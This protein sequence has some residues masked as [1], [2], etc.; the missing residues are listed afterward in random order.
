[1]SL[2][3][4][5]LV[6]QVE[7]VL[8]SSVEP[9][10][11]CASG[12]AEASVFSRFST[13][14]V[15]LSCRRRFKG[16]NQ[17]GELIMPT[18]IGVGP[19]T[20]RR[21][22]VCQLQG[23]TVVDF[24]NWDIFELG[25][26]PEVVN[27]VHRELEIEGIGGASPRMLGGYSPALHSAELVWAKFMRAESAMLVSS[28]NQALFSLMTQRLSRGGEVLMF[29]GGASPMADLA[30]LCGASFYAVTEGGLKKTLREL[31]PR[32]EGERR[33]FFL[34]VG[35]PFI[36]F[37]VDYVA[38]LD[39]LIAEGVEVIVDDTFSLGV[40]GSAG[41]GLLDQLNSAYPVQLGLAGLDGTVG[42]PSLAIIYGTKEGILDVQKSSSVLKSEPPPTPAL[43]AASE[44]ACRQLQV[45][46]AQRIEIARRLST[47]A[48]LLGR[49]GGINPRVH[50]NCCLTLRVSS[51]QA[52]LGLQRAL[53]QE[54]YL[55]GVYQSTLDRDPSCI[56]VF[57]LS[58]FHSDQVLLAAARVVARII[59]ED[60]LA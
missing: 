38:L 53:I 15:R 48:E 27:A 30:E 41:G 51:M 1:M 60:A 47:F 40:L 9:A 3:E 21:F 37:E 34:E 39:L 6:S 22:G 35:H 46:G 54:G 55:C 8:V 23:R 2:V 26:H 33:I 45:L 10:H 20:S 59:K 16:I 13:I 11:V 42:L 56:V 31:G 57:V 36:Q 19:Y 18:E 50:N 49:L 52:G 58:L 12:N 25:R 24:T 17:V 44:V 5:V 28:R 4:P 32:R 43:A 14:F 7:P 29:A